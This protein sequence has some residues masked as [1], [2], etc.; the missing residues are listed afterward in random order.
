MTYK[1]KFFD[2]IKSNAFKNFILFI[3]FSIAMTVVISSQNFFFQ[4]I[5]ENGVS[6]QDIVAQKNITVVDTIRTE[7][8]KK[9]VAR[10]VEPI[11]TQAN[12]DFIRVNLTNLRNTILRIRDSKVS[13]DKKFNEISVLFDMPRSPEKTAMVEFLR[14]SDTETF[15]RLFN[16]AQATL[17][18]VLNIGITAEDFEKDKIKD[19]IRK[20]MYQSIPHG[21]SRM[22][23]NI[24]SQV[25]VPNLI[26]DEFA[27]EIA[28]RNAENSVKPYEV[29]FKKG[30]TIIFEGEQITKVKSDALREA[31]Y[32]VLEINY[33]GIAGIFFIIALSTG[34][35]LMYL[36]GFEK[37]FLEPNYLRLFAFMSI[38]ISLFPVVLPTGFSPYI[39]PFPAF[40]IILSIFTTPRVAL[41]AANLILVNLAIGLHYGIEMVASFLLLNTFTMIAVYNHKFTQ[42][43]DLIYIG[44]KIATAGGLILGCIYL[45]EKFLMNIDNM[46]I[47]KDVGYIVL[48]SFVIGGLL[49]LGFLPVLEKLFQMISPYAL[50][51]FAD[52]NQQQ[53]LKDLQLKAPGTYNH[54]MMVAYLCDAA[55]EAIGANPLLA[56]VGAIYHDVGKLKR[57]MFFVENQ[58]SY[59]IENP[60]NNC[61]PKFSKMLITAHP[62]DGVELAKDNKLPPIINNFIL[63][64]HGTGLVSYFYNQAVAQDGAENVAEDQFRYPGPKPNSK[65]TAILMIAD[66]VESTVR[67]N[68]ASSA[69]EIDNIINKII[70]DRLN[71]GQL[72]EA[73]IT[74]KDLS[75]IAAV[76]SRI[77]RGIHHE[78]IKYQQDLVKE[79]DRNKTA[80]RNIDKDL[81]AKIQELESKRD[82]H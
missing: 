47:L 81:E 74:L 64:H 21:Q 62:K 38:F 17:D 75:T 30:D 12:D 35:F 20:G 2:F 28:R 6:K 57:P 76:M 7:Q 73:P 31:G 4:Q 24:L 41:L 5:I 61:S 58:S 69:E 65:E 37:N 44:F 34:M 52:Q 77:L 36:K 60:H 25:I 48:N 26:V 15:T 49:T 29:T 23:V 9:E 16:R 14:D 80:V 3:M 54:S 78:R 10:K 8:H 42:R 46:L 13:S 43:N 79:L 22:I 70:K 32:N 39:I 72:S 55:A 11:L 71:D 19:I 50:V 18:T 63:Q 40:M 45:L 68:K 51:E 27:T 33:F 1:E 67:A 59:G 82:E 66:A 56:K 53:L